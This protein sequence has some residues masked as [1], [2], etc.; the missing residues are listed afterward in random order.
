MIIIES[1]LDIFK[2]AAPALA[3]SY[4]THRLTVNREEYRKQEVRRAYAVLFKAA[5]TSYMEHL[6]SDTPL[7]PWRSSLWEQNQARLAEFFPQLVYDFAK[8]Q[9]HHDDFS[10]VG[11]LSPLLPDATSFDAAL[12]ELQKIWEALKKEEEKP[13]LTWWQYTLQWWQA[14]LPLL[15]RCKRR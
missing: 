11:V 13:L 2:A 15:A 6:Q 1:L 7:V 14:H 5:V 12:S 8:L 9:S 4:F 3:A 10:S